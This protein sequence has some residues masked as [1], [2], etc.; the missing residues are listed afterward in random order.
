MLDRLTQLIQQF[1]E[2]TIVKNQQVPNGLNDAV[3]KEAG[4]GLLDAL[5]GIA[6]SGQASLLTDLLKGSGNQNLVV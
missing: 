3:K 4:N 2:Q 5:S 6:N 1:G